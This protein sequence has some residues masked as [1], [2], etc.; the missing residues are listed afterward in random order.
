LALYFLDSSALVKRY[1]A[2]TGSSWVDSLADP[3]AGH[4]IFVA[5]I[6]EVE[7]VSAVVRRARGGS[8]AVGDAATILAQFRHDLRH[9]YQVLDVT[10]AVMNQ[11][12]GYAEAHGLRASDAI[13][14]AAVLALAA[15]A[16]VTA[17]AAPVI[18]SADQELNQA[19]SAEGL[20][21]EDP[22]SHP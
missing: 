18:V 10:P 5:G 1:V 16:R 21:V 6:T 8:I 12:A 13:Q 22:R 3:S 11:A 9:D 14:L 20:A 17:L 4:D 7:V 2:E 19:A 15:S